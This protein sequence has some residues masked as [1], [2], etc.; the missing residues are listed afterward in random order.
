MVFHPP[1]G[2]ADSGGLQPAKPQSPRLAH[3]SPLSLRGAR[4]QRLSRTALCCPAAKSE[5]FH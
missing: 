3:S 4:V 5:D 2:L 1:A